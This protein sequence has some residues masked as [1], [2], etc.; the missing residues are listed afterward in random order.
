VSLPGPA[1]HGVVYAPG[2]GDYFL[3]RSDRLIVGST[4]EAAGFDPAVDPAGTD[5]LRALAARWFPAS[6]NHTASAWAGLRPMTP[7]GLPLVGRDPDHPALIYATGHSRNGVLLMPITAEAVGALSVGE[8]PGVD[9]TPWRP[10][11][12]FT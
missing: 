10:D 8:A 5:R 7:D 6:V 1:P 12:V 2:G 4:T 3:P 9:L 11:R